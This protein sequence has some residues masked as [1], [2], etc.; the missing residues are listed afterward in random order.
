MIDPNAFRN[1]QI[2]GGFTIAR[3]DV[4]DES[5]FDAIGREAIARTLMK[6]EAVRQV[7]PENLDRLLQLYGF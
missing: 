7:S 1:V 2:R 5:L 3:I 4:S 6:R